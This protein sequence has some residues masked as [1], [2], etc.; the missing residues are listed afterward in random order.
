M[1]DEVIEVT[2]EKDRK[3]ITCSHGTPS[4]DSPHVT[5]KLINPGQK[6]TATVNIH[7]GIL[8]NKLKV[9]KV[10]GP[11]AAV[12]SV[13]PIPCSICSSPTP[14]GCPRCDASFRDKGKD[15][16]NLTPKEW[17]KKYPDFPN[18]A[19]FMQTQI[20]AA[21]NEYMKGEAGSTQLVK[22]ARQR[23]FNEEECKKPVTMKVT[24]DLTLT[25]TG[26]MKVY[27]FGSNCVLTETTI[28]GQ[29]LTFK[30]LNSDKEF[31]IPSR[32]GANI[33]ATKT[34]NKSTL[35][36]IEFK[37]PQMKGDFI[38]GPCYYKK[39]TSPYFLTPECVDVDSIR[40]LGQLARLADL[41]IY[42]DPA[43]RNRIYPFAGVI[44]FRN[45]IVAQIGQEAE[46]K[47]KEFA[48]S[49]VQL[50]ENI[51]KTRPD[52]ICGIGYELLGINVS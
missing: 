37:C 21:C 9:K 41:E 4:C 6:E 27:Y 7:A 11:R 45:A 46:S 49:L 10:R 31:T 28:T 17:A 20:I 44:P 43:G 13:G 1:S 22:L 48:N 52:S 16:T 39:A 23:N 8:A 32:P 33:Y 47:V 51:R 2:I 15:L 30:V 19:E 34:T 29:P 40:D 24:G 35:F 18:K 5:V 42:N 50:A 12:V 26:S 14:K 25:V 36:G 38:C 3:A